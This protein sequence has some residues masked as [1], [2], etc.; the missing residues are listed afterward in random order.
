MNRITILYRGV[1]AAAVLWSCHLPAQTRWEH[2]ADHP[3]VNYGAG[4]GWDDITVFW[5]TVV[6]EG[7]ILHMWYAGGDNVLGSGTVQIGYATSAR[8]VIWRRAE[9]NPVLRPD[10]SWEGGSVLSPTVIKDDGIFRMWYGA[11]GVPSTAVGYAT[12]PDGLHWQKH[13]LPVLQR[14]APGEWD[15]SIIGP[16]TVI[17][18]N[19]I[20]KMW[21]W[22][23]RGS[24]PESE[25]QIGLAVST[26]GIKWFKQ[27]NPATVQAPFRQSDPVVAAG[28]PGAW[29]FLRVWSPA[30]L[31]TASGY[32]MWYTGREDHFSTAQL[33]GYAT[34]ADGITWVKFPGN[35][36][37]DTPPEWGTSYLT[38]AILKFDGYYHLWFTSFAFF[39]LGQIGAIGYARSPLP[40]SGIDTGVPAGYALAQ[41]QPNPFNQSTRI[42]FDLPEQTAVDMAVYDLMGRRIK[43]LVR[44]VETAGFKIVSWDG[45][46]ESGHAVASG[47]YIYQLRTDSFRQSRKLLLIK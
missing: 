22:G 21:Y 36:V 13:P 20:F 2:V 33:V 14:G 32:E 5:P 16:G 39:G 31:A 41:N 24:W 45:T 28:V 46:G 12:S 47:V 17:R 11:G 23:G 34:S 30:V 38:S 25:I 1:L 15:S 37:I 26:D 9:E 29:D 8:G 7:E 43:T 44:G 35:P 27:D 10:L 40:P 6:K 18:E 4:N 3:V 19:N 42:R